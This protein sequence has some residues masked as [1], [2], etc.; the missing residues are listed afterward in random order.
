MKNHAKERG[1]LKLFNLTDRVI[2]TYKYIHN[3]DEQHTSDVYFTTVEKNI[4]C[5]LQEQNAL[6][7]FSS[8]S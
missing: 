2:Y 3:K 7:S 4:L 5:P 1:N 8:G 6:S